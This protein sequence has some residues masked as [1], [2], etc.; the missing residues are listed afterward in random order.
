MVT[1]RFVVFH[2]APSKLPP[3][4]PPRPPRVTGA[5]SDG[6]AACAEIL[7]DAARRG[8]RPGGANAAAPRLRRDPKETP[9]PGHKSARISSARRVSASAPGQ[10]DSPRRPALQT[11]DAT[12]QDPSHL[13]PPTLPLRRK[14]ATPRPRRLGRW[15]GRAAAKRS[16]ARDPFPSPSSRG[17]RRARSPA[18][19]PRPRAPSPQKT[20]TCRPRRTPARRSCRFRCERAVLDGSFKI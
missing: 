11:A 6:V 9:P 15:S 1:E 12:A 4:P 7:A 5:A 19:E 2:D 8:S 13:L 3:S 18:I 17:S 10:R 20:S 16:D 14:R